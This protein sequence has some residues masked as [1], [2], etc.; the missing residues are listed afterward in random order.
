VSAGG[1]LYRGGIFMKRSSLLLAGGLGTRLEGREKALLL[2]NGNTFIENT[3]QVLDR[4]C[5]EVIISFRDEAQ[6]RQFGEY[7]HGRK[8]VLDTL[9]HAGP[10]AGM[11][12]GFRAASREY[13]LVVACDMPYINADVIDR[14]FKLAEGH[15]AVVPVGDSGK[16]EPLHAVYKRVPML[17]AIEVSLLE[18][19]RFVMSPV[20][21]LNDV[22]FP[23]ART[24]DDPENGIT[25]FIN[26][27]TPE[28]LA[29]L[30]DN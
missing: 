2:L 9:Q 11:L 3:L 26:I 4:V 27:N 23:E 6:L 18:G 29:K 21:K 8:T 22:M 15:D 10:L 20:L 1:D 13:V 30:K 24:L 5:D 19:D 7:V 17:H 25:T 16:K 14:L 12:E 28:D